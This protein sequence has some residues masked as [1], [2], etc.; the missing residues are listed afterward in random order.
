MHHKFGIQQNQT[1]GKRFA[2]E[3]Q[4][5]WIYGRHGLQ[6]R[7]IPGYRPPSSLLLWLEELGTDDFSRRFDV[8]NL[9][10]NLRRRYL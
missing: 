9:M 5:A 1:Q 6:Y 7:V 8:R 2:H 10:R 3:R 4:G